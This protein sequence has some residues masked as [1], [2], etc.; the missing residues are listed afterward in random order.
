MSS[1]TL[2]TGYPNLAS[3]V[4]G[5]VDP[6]VERLLRI[7]F[8]NINTIAQQVATLQAESTTLKAQVAALLA[9]A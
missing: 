1:P 2:N 8:D 3:Q 9:K 5:K 4:A 7:L 6:S